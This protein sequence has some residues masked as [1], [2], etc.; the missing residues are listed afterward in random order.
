M[1]VLSRGLKF[2]PKPDKSNDEQL[3]ND[4]SIFHRKMKLKG[5][6]YE[7]EN[8]QEETTVSLNHLKEE[9][10]AMMSTLK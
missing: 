7:N 5:D 6:F 4:I 3:S 8:I 10:K 2:T 1:S 9:I